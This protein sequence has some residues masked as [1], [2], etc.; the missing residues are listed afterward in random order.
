MWH[1]WGKWACRDFVGKPEGQRVL[2]R[3][4]QMW[5]GNVKM[6]LKEVGW[7]A[8]TGLIWHKIG[9]GGGSCECGAL[10]SEFHKM[11]IAS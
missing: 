1:I 10:T 11:W 6:V 3:Y 7:E 9:T 4:R 8:W 5:E 2:G